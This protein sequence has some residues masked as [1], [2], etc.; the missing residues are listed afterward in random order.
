MS[1]Q[2]KIQ[3]AVRGMTCG[4]CAT[5]VVKALESVPGVQSAVVADWKAGQATLVAD[6]GLDEQTLVTALTA[7]G[8][9]GAI[10]RR[11]PMREGSAPEFSL[12]TPEQPMADSCCAPA[13]HPMTKPVAVARTANLC[14]ECGQK[15]KSID[16][17][18]VKAMLS[19]SL[20]QVR[21]VSYLFCGTADC[22]VVYF[23][24]DGEQA[25]TTAQVRERVHQKEP[26]GGDVFVCYC[27]RHTPDSIRAEWE[28]TGRSTVIDA[29]N[30]GIRAGQCACGIRNPQGS[31][32]LGNVRAVVK[33]VEE[34]TAKA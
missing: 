20:T 5:H 15:G 2:E 13:A 8:Y 16:S 28:T 9:G 4:G 11:H 25:F 17:L 31:C 6:A 24:E 7:A 1:G 10:Q 18:T 14:P 30:A 29:V 3:L 12:E 27:F 19:V 33:Q 22:P 21:P 32:C 23:S 26:N 34:S